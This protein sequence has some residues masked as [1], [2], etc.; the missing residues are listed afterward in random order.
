MNMADNYNEVSRGIIVSDANGGKVVMNSEGLYV[1]VN[2]D[3]AEALTGLKAL[4]R[5]AKETTKA[6]RELENAQDFKQTFDSHRRFKHVA[7]Y[8]TIEMQNGESISV[9]LGAPTGEDRCV[10]IN[11]HRGIKHVFI[12]DEI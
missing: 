10:Y 11:G 1:K 9:D 5:E 8:L 12:S 3:I 7:K 6:L 2:V 4:Q